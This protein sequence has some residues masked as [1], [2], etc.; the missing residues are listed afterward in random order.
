M[1]SCH[2]PFS[3]AYMHLF[4]CHIKSCSLGMWTHMHPSSSLHEQAS[5]PSWLSFCVMPR[6]CV[7]NTETICRYTVTMFSFLCSL[8]L[9]TLHYAHWQPMISRAYWFPSYRN[10][11]FRTCILDFNADSWYFLHFEL[12]SIFMLYF[13]C[14][15]SIS[16]HIIFCLSLVYCF[17]HTSN[18]C[19]IDLG[20]VRNPY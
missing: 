12:L 17:C 4:S 15:Y 6:H 8:S 3:H 2:K 11:C 9:L 10:P 19:Y 20:V 14:S 5:L 13:S 7:F 16:T 18:L 1:H